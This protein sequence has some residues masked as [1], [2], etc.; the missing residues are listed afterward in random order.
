M[1]RKAMVTA[2]LALACGLWLVADASAQQGMGGPGGGRR[3]RRMYNSQTVETVR[4]E[5]VNVRTLPSRRGA[6]GG[7]VHVTLKTDKETID[8]HVGP[9]WY[10]AEKGVKL[11]P[12]DQLE[13]RG[14]R[15]TFEGKPAIIAAEVTKAGKSLRLRDDNGL[16]VWRGR[17]P[18]GRMP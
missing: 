5:V 14:S 1:Q 15:V 13:V 17:G 10:L 3:G 6:A 2:G 7:G 11:A 9:S 16:P 4:G 8:V 18:R 12:K